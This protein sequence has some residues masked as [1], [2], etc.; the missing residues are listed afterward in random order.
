[1]AL[2]GVGLAEEG[3]FRVPGTAEDIKVIK[4]DYDTGIASGIHACARVEIKY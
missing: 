2:M 4:R 1:M 3:I